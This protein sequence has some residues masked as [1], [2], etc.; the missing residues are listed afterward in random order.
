M[1]PDKQI[2][3][4]EEYMKSNTGH[5]I[6][7]QKYNQVLIMKSLAVFVS[8]LKVKQQEC[9]HFDFDPRKVHENKWFSRI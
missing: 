7:L 8:T 6:M 9:I 1:P 3:I 4:Y 2:I 5:Y